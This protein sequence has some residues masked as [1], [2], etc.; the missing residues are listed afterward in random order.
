MKLLAQSLI[1]T[2]PVPYTHLGY[3]AANAERVTTSPPG[4]ES[5]GIYG[6][7]LT[8]I[9]VILLF[10]VS[11]AHRLWRYLATVVPLAGI[12]LLLC[13]ALID[14]MGTPRFVSPKHTMMLR[15]LNLTI[16]INRCLDAGKP[17]PVDIATLV[18]NSPITATDPRKRLHTEDVWGTPFRITRQQQE[19][20]LWYDVISAG[21]DRR[22]GTADDMTQ[23]TKFIEINHR[24]APATEHHP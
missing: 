18:L 14:R 19:N 15:M 24:K 17:V 1:P 12:G 7:I 2:N 16:E 6:F 23:Q 10:R 20:D 21:P 4:Y 22:F 8:I 9:G 5:L 11:Y 3:I 13:A